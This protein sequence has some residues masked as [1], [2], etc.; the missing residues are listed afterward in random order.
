MA[1]RLSRSAHVPV[2]VRV[3]LVLPSQ[4][5]S[6]AERSS[7][8]VH[9]PAIVVLVPQVRRVAER[10]STSAHVPVSPWVDVPPKLL[11]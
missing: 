4:Y 6:V 11:Q 1:E 5:H 8:S 10:S 3:R 7:T 2:I 9:V